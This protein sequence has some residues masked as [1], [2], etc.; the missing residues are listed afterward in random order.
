MILKHGL[1]ARCIHQQQIP[2]PKGSLYVLCRLALS[3]KSF[4]KYPSLPVLHCPG[5][6]PLAN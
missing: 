3:D 4:R 1:C 2:S 6:Q 5:F